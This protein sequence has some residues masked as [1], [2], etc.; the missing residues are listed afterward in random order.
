MIRLKR[1]YESFKGDALPEDTVFGARAGVAT[2][3][4]I[5]TGEKE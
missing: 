3:R 5:L 4:P 2:G 1:Q